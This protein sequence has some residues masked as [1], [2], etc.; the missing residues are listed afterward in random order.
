MQLPQPRMFIL[1]IAASIAGP[2]ASTGAAWAHASE[3]GHF[4][5]PATGHHIVGGVLLVMAS[6]AVMALVDP[7]LLKRTGVG[8][9]AL[10][11]CVLRGRMAASLWSW[12]VPVALL[13]SDSLDG[14]MRSFF[15]LGLAAS[16][17]WRF[18]AAAPSSGRAPSASP[19]WRACS[20]APSSWPSFSASGWPENAAR[21]GR[22]PRLVSDADRAR[23]SC[24]PRA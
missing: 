5:L 16:I 9:A 6:F 15:W 11:P 19:P 14:L 20:A 4:L 8:K 2:T 12:L 7:V 3:R 13:A 17:R 21:H 18:P 24:R 23:L 22:C 1:G 10:G